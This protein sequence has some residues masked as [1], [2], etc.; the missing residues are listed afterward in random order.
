MEG[1][2]MKSRLFVLLCGLFA[3]ALPAS[4][5][6]PGPN[7]Q[8]ALIIGNANY[9]DSDTPL[10]SAVGDARAIAGELRNDGFEVDVREN[11]GKEAL[12]RA[13][14]AFN[15]K[16]HSGTVALFYFS[17][18]GL[19]VARQTYLFPVDAQV[20]SEADAKKDGISLDAVVAEMHRRGAHIKIV[21]VD[22]SRRNPFERRFRPTPGGLAA[23]DA[24][25]NTLAIYSAAPGAVVNDSKASPSLF[26]GE[27]I[28]EM[29]VPNVTA[30]AAFN[31][32]RMGVS[33][34]SNDEQIPW[35]AST[36]TDDY[37]FQPSG[38]A[39]VNNTPN[40]V[41]PPPVAPPQL[42]SVPAL[43]SSVPTTPTPATPTSADL[44]ALVASFI[45]KYE[46]A[47]NNKDTN[48]DA[49]V[50]LFTKDA[51]YFNVN[52][53]ELIVGPAALRAVFARN[54]GNKIKL[55]DYSVIQ[56][57]PNVLLSSGYVELTAPDG[58]IF[59]YR[60][61]WA[62]VKADGN[63][64]IAQSHTSVLPRPPAPAA[65][66]LP[67]SASA[68]GDC[69]SSPTKLGQSGGG[70]GVAILAADVAQY[71]AAADAARTKATQTG[72]MIVYDNV[73]P[74]GTTQFSS[75]LFLIGN[76]NPK[77]VIYCGPNSAT[78]AQAEKDSGL[79]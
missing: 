15:G 63:W 18:F 64:L 12:Q 3:A 5:Q 61:T 34:A 58:R 21:I 30:E 2:E 49:L 76:A 6:Q 70:S 53:P 77:L 40:P 19:Q 54:R 62:L 13:I 33:R 42:P 9:P 75:Y 59:P 41:T 55:G 44:K 37:S 10:A 24:P 56:V 17:G 8:I 23:L 52:L 20:W 28:K 79:L 26:A 32:T 27:L 4:A 72:D 78:F 29:R 31:Q 45:S 38:K 60:V 43:P 22:A 66:T 71:K 48:P 1:A 68:S 65:P 39:A 69:V 57:A 74:A 51:L 73:F 35:V 25:Q 67:P 11:A 46:D 47:Y 16:I 36:L 14:D 7:N 50:A